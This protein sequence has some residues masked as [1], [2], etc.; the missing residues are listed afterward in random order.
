MKVHA[1]T[2]FNRSLLDRCYGQLRFRHAAW[3]S[4]RR[5]R[6]KHDERGI[7]ARATAAVEHD[8]NPITRLSKWF[9]FEDEKESSALPTLGEL[10]ETVGTLTLPDARLVAMAVVFLVLLS[11]RPLCVTTIRH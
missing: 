3:P 8:E 10:A 6:T 9:Q 5:S 4:N 11:A 7:T 2:S 1:G